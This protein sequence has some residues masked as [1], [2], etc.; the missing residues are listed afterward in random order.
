MENW[1]DY[2][3]Q[4]DIQRAA[5]KVEFSDKEICC[6]LGSPLRRQVSLKEVLLWLLNFQP[7]R[8]LLRF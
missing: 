6:K 4:G 8:P 7:P 1:R 2:M 3:K 5:N